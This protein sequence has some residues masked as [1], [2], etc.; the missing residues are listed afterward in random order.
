MREATRS[1]GVEA[2]RAFIHAC[3]LAPAGERSRGCIEEL[4]AQMPAAQDLERRIGRNRLVPQAAAHLDRASLPK[5]ALPLRDALQAMLPILAAQS[6]LHAAELLGILR[7]LRARGVPALPFKGPAFAARYC[8]SLLRECDDLDIVVRGDDL[9]RAVNALEDAGYSRRETVADAMLPSLRRVSHEI[10]LF[11]HGRAIHVELHWRLS[12]AWHAAVIEE[13]HLFDDL[14]EHDLAGSTVAAPCPEHLLLM[15]V[16]DGAK[17]PGSGARWLADLAAILRKEYAL[18]WRRVRE[19][20]VEGGGLNSLRIAMA[21]LLGTATA[22]PI[23]RSAIDVDSWFAPEARSLADE[24]S[25]SPL[26][27]RA[28]RHIV[29]H[30]ADGSRPVRAMRQFL[31]SGI[32]SDSRAATAV[33]I[34]RYLSGPAAVDLSAAE[35]GGDPGSLRAASLRRRLRGLAANTAPSER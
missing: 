33:G 32:V 20:A 18:D 9:V 13:R 12:P 7:V 10:S 28:V 29:E 22:A 2:A 19:R 16:A 1:S 6:K 34:L 5:S 8:G 27:R 23:L 21:A 14:S 30:C 24:A 3:A 35:R 31:W 26:L 15:H 4:L 11:R 25:R 17:T